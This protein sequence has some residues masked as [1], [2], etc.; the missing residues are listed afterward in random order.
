MITKIR[1]SIQQM[2]LEEY[3]IKVRYPIIMYF[4]AVFA[5]YGILAR[6]CYSLFN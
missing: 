3:G 6:V 1:D 2:F 5:S 4:T